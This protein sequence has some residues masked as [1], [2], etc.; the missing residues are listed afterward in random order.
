MGKRISSTQTGRLPLALLVIAFAMIS[1]AQ[2]YG[3]SQQ[4]E[5]ALDRYI[6]AGDPVFA[7]EV[8]GEPVSQGLFSTITLNLVS[9]QWQGNSWSHN[10]TI[11]TPLLCRRADR[12]P[13][14]ST[15]CAA[16]KRP[17]GFECDRNSHSDAHCDSGQRAKPAPLRAKGRRSHC[18]HIRQVSRN[19]RRNLAPASP[20]DQE[21]SGVHGRT[22]IVFQLRRTIHSQ[23]VHNHGRLQERLDV[24]AL[25]SS[26]SQSGR[27]HADGLR[28]PELKAQMDNRYVGR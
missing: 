23:W 9:Q 4:I 18:I 22:R 10:V 26:R 20:D 24:V 11:Y 14:W 27:H 17:S 19:R 8:V 3:S 12:S 5:T 21:R 1:T 28:Q 7:Y 6:S 25:C 2:A 15:R 13:F 16:I